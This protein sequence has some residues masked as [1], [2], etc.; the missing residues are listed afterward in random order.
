MLSVASFGLF[1]LVYKDFLSFLMCGVSASLSA[2]AEISA[3]LAWQAQDMSSVLSS[4][5]CFRSHFAHAFFLTQYTYVH[6]N[7]ATFSARMV[8]LSVFVS[9]CTQQ[10]SCFLLSGIVRKAIK[11]SKKPDY[12][13]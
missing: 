7:C 8:F 6:L 9:G 4:A 11:K 12:S 10:G 13:A 5:I 2:A 3:A 1:L